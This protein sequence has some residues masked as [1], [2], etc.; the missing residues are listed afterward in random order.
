MLKEFPLDTNYLISEKGEVFSKISGKYL[1]PTKPGKRGYLSFNYKRDGKWVHMLIHR[2]VAMCFIPNPSGLPCVNHLDGNKTN[3]HS[4]NLEWCTDRQN[5]N[6][7]KDNSLIARGSVHH[8]TDKTED[9]IHSICSD[10][11]QGMTTGEVVSKYNVSRGTA[12]N[13]RC[14]RTWVHVSK[15]YTWPIVP[16]RVNKRKRAETIESTS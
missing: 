5:K 8:N 6:H 13:I 15:D 9:M 14:R 12:L 11:S 2:A 16:Q 3:N 10:L 4:S 1:Q 7:A